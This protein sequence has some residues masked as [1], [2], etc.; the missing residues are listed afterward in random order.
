MFE[1]HL[2]IHSLWNAVHEQASMTVIAIIDGHEVT[3]FVQLVCACE[4][5]RTRTDNSD[6]LSGTE[7][8]DLRLHPAYLKGLVAR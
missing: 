4:P 5:C 8:W 7:C 6:F 3:S 2:A 1:K